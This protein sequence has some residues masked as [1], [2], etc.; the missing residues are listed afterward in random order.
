M[1]LKR[2]EDASSVVKEGNR[3]TGA[4]CVMVSDVQNWK[5]G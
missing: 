2:K 5:E 3:R 4:S 1:E